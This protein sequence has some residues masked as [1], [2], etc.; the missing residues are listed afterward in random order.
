MTFTLF[1]DLLRILDSVLTKYNHSSS[2]VFAAIEPLVLSSL[3]IS[4]IVYGWLILRGVI[5]MPFSYFISRSLRIGIITSIAMAGGL[6]QN[7]IRNVVETLPE[8][9]LASAYINDYNT[10]YDPKNQ[11]K[12]MSVILDMTANMGFDRA[13]LAF[14]ES[15]FLSSDGTLYGFFGILILLITSI[16]VAIGGVFLVMTKLIF[17]FLIAFGPIFILTLL[18]QSTYRF[19]ERWAAQTVCYTI[20]IVLL[21]IMLPY[22]LRIFYN[23]VDNIK[24]DGSQ[25]IGYTLGGAVILFIFFVMFLFKLSSLANTLTKGLTLGHLW[26]TQAVGRKRQ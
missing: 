24:F 14:E 20:F 1:T 11:Y 4:F 15:A 10:N 22:I 3:T 25:N 19:F 26:G 13:N 16:L 5:D 18:W 17:G 9:A 23:Y 8:S 21:H 6:Y 12:K 7:N 2:Q